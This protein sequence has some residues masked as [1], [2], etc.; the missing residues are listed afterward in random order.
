MAEGMSYPPGPLLG[1]TCVLWKLVGAN[2][3]STAD[4]PFARTFGFNA[5]TINS[6]IVN[7]ASTSLTLAVGGI[8]GAVAKGA[9]LLAPATQIYSAL[10]G[11][12][13]V[14]NTTATALSGDM[15]TLS[16][17]FLSLT[18]G[19]GATATADYYVVGIAWT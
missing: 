7:N 4:Q 10:T 19:Q 6:I 8:Y 15:Q 18:T 17:I 16:S 14:L 1:T 3:N 5:F 11:P 13:K 2:M 9:P 12:T